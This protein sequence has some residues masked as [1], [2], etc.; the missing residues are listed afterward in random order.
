MPTAK[1]TALANITLS[2]TA[3]TVTFGS[4]PNTY[5]DLKLVIQTSTSSALAYVMA[6]LNGD[7]GTNYGYMVAQEYNG[8]ASSN[9]YASATGLQLNGDGRSS[10]GKTAMVTADIFD[11]AQ[12]DKHKSALSRSA[13]VGST[14]PGTAMVATR[15]YSTVAVTSVTLFTDTGSFEAGSTFTLYG[16]K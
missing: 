4:I 10:T 12:T 15:W 11:Y 8:S 6:R 7:T 14:Y 1:Y 16:V 2:S 13:M 3:S 5:R 9:T